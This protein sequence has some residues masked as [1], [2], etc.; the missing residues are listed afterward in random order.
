MSSPNK[1]AFRMVLLLIIVMII[2]YLLYEPLRDAFEGNR[3]INGLIIF[4]FLSGVLL[5]F[6]QTFRL[7]KE[8]NW[9][10]FVKKNDVFLP[11]NYKTS[12]IKPELLAPIAA[13][14]LEKKNDSWRCIF[15]VR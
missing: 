2:S 9:L 8:R 11:D 14:L 7:S 3:E 1:Y 6:R 10:Q 15:K 5:S 12:K 13:L 4:T